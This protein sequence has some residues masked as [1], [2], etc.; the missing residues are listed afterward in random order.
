M[1][2]EKWNGSKKRN[3]NE[4]GKGK[5]DDEERGENCMKKNTKNKKRTRKLCSSSTKRKE[6]F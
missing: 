5:D 3:E 4:N 2:M 1:H 6:I